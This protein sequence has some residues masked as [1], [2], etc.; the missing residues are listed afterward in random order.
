[1]ELL[2]A[3]SEIISSILG[4]PYTLLFTDNAAA[5]A[6]MVGK[7][8]SYLAYPVANKQERIASILSY[9]HYMPNFRALFKK[10]KSEYLTK[11]KI[12]VEFQ[13]TNLETMQEKVDRLLGLME[14]NPLTDKRIG[15]ELGDTDYEKH[16][17]QDKLKEQKEERKQGMQPGGQQGQNPKTG[18][19][20]TIRDHATNN[21]TKQTVTTH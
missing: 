21:K 17:D 1:M 4:V 18:Q 11:Y 7:M 10:R 14:I 19:T 6:T 5:R 3:L 13:E 20:M 9:Q 15:E 8:V 12:G 16:V 2:R